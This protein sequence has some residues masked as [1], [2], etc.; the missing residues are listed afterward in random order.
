MLT[1]NFSL[2]FWLSKTF[3][4]FIIWYGIK[5]L[6]QQ[7]LKK[8]GSKHIKKN[9]FETTDVTGIKKKIKIKFH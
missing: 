6:K 5:E 7:Q 1:E 4:S 2:L 9:I 3:V 8:C